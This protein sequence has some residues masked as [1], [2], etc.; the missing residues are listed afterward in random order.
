[1][2]KPKRVGEAE[3]KAVESPELTEREFKRMRPASQAVPRVVEAS[4]R[5]R[6]R[7]KQEIT[8]ELVSMRLSPTVLAHFRGQ[9]PGWQ[10]RVNSFLVE[11]VAIVGGGNMPRTEVTK[12]LWDYIKRNQLQATSIR[13]SRRISE[14]GTDRKRSSDPTNRRATAIRSR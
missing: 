8:K 2:K 14:S 12:K 6:G 1:M 7:P 11:F 13:R 4:R 5:A 10:T 3:W 9:G